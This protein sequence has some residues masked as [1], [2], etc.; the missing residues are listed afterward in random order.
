MH[1][2]YSAARGGRSFLTESGRGRKFPVA[3]RQ[4]ERLE[5]TLCWLR[6]A[7]RQLVAAF[8]SSSPVPAP[9]GAISGFL[10]NGRRQVNV[11]A[12]RCR[13]I[14]SRSADAREEGREELFGKF[15]RVDTKLG[16]RGALPV[17]RAEPGADVVE[18]RGG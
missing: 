1:W 16:D 2:T 6:F 10:R 11:P 18:I 9:G 15:F 5:Q 3:D 14:T 8:R 13:C 4:A 7:Y 12:R 17:G